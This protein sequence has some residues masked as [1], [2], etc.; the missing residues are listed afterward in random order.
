MNS[1]EIKLDL[2]RRIDGMSTAE[3]EKVYDKVLA[4]ISSSNEYVLSEAERNAV[5][6]ALLDSQYDSSESTEAIVA[7]AKQKYPNLKFK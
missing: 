3:L 6:E 4:L 5:E 1:A 2:F 7:E